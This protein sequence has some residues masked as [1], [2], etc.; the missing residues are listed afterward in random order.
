MKEFIFLVRGKDNSTA[1]EV[2]QQQMETFRAWIQELTASGKYKGGQP[3]V[4]DKARLVRSKTE[5]LD[6]GYFLNAK[7][8]IR[9]YLQ[10]NAHDFDEATAIAQTYPLLDQFP[11]EV[12]EVKG[13]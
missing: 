9:G 13:R 10:I 1:P 11:V 6:E 3:L 2:L 12:R 8:V 7:Q 5:V 4:N